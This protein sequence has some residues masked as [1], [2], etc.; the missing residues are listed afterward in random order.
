[1]DYRFRLSSTAFPPS[2]FAETAAV[3]VGASVVIT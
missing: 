2:A 1:M 3:A